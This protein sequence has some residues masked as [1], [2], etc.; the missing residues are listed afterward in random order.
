MK[1]HL[2][3]TYLEDKPR[4]TPDLL[5][6]ATPHHDN[7]MQRSKSPTQQQNS[8][9]SG[10]QTDNWPYLRVQRYQKHLTHNQYAFADQFL[11]PGAASKSAMYSRTTSVTTVLN[12]LT[13]T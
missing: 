1:Q 11:M 13:F 4:S 2:K 7:M 12:D 8:P 10:N 5:A 6:F 3:L 9:F